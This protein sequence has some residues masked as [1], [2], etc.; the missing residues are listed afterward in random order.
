MKAKVIKATPQNVT[1]FSITF[2][3]QSFPGKKAKMFAEKDCAGFDVSI[4]VA[5]SFIHILTKREK[6]VRY[7]VLI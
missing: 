2:V 5:L 7:T 3:L 1:E 6:K 4:I